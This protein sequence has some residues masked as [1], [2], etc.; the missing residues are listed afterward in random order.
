METKVQPENTK[1][2]SNPLTLVTLLKFLLK[3][4]QG[5]SGYYGDRIILFP[6]I[7]SVLPNVLLMLKFNTL[8]R[9]YLGSLRSFSDILNNIY[10]ASVETNIKLTNV[11]NQ[12][13]LVMGDLNVLSDPAEKL[14]MTKG[15]STRYN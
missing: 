3:V 7:S 12:S 6:S 2:F 5:E 9:I 8:I 4:I 13:W 10:K 15:T 14:S 11:K 1:R